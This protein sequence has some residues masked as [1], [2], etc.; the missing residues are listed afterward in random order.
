M[1]ASGVDLFVDVHGDEDLPFA[2]I[3]GA[4][5]LDIW[6]PRI[7]ALQGAF[8]GAFSR[9]NPDMQAKFGYAP[10]LP[11][12]GN[13]AI[14]SNQVAQRFDCLG[15]TLEMPFKDCAAVPRQEPHA[16]GFDGRRASMLGASLCD[17]VAHVASQLRGAPEPSFPLPDD[18]YVAP[19]EDASAIAAWVAEKN[20]RG[21]SV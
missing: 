9:A 10:D 16:A 8:V 2:F 11:K 20:A 5:G 14:C 6:G 7:R 21:S 1:D 15:V 17:A 19:V 18:Q 4:E 3:A 12:A 13:L